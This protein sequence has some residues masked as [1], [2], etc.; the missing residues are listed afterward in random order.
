VDEAVCKVIE[1][2]A[3]F[4]AAAGT[5]SDSRTSTPARIKQVIVVGAT[6]RNDA[7][8]Y[9]SNFGPGLD[10]YAP[11]VD[12]ESDT[13]TGGTTTM[14]GTSMACPHVVGAIALYLQR[15]PEATVA[16]AEAGIVAQ[17]S[18]DKLTGLGPESPNRL[19]YVREN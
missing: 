15:H 12:I 13:P 2:G 3:V 8:A 11:G 5:R 1:S 19:L 7:Q 10:T 14:S 4:V 6:D 18:K 9:F 17:A 16:E